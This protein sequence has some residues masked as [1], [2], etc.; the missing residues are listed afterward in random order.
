MTGLHDRLTAHCMSNGTEANRGAGTAPGDLVKH[1]LV[2]QRALHLA[3]E[4]A[5]NPVTAG[6]P[7]DSLKAHGQFPGSS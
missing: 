6:I 5:Q 3:A 4:F 2:A 7:L 1:L